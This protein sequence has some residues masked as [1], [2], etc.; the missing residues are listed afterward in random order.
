MVIATVREIFSKDMDPTSLD[1][2]SL[3]AIT[4]W[5]RLMELYN[6]IVY[7]MSWLSNQAF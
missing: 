3:R 6:S 1:G 5:A 7:V 2:H 4:I